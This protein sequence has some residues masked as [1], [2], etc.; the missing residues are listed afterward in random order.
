MESEKYRRKMANGLAFSMNES[1]A[2]L[3]TA[4]DKTGC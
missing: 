2:I 4:V 3:S 1:E